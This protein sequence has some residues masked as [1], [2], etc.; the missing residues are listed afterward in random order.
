MDSK[1]YLGQNMLSIIS[2]SH[3]YKLL[4]T[5]IMDRIVHEKWDGVNNE[6]HSLIAYSTSYQVVY[7]RFDVY[8]GSDWFKQTIKQ[9]CTW[10]KSELSHI[11]KLF[12]WK[13]SMLL[14]INIEFVILTAYS[15]LFLELIIV[16]VNDLHIAE[17]EARYLLLKRVDYYVENGFPPEKQYLESGYL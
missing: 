6:T 14:R 9:A 2:K 11:F 7:D 16:F 8:K 10:D 12:I 5:K 17:H 4:D 3:L 13:K 15:L 1:D